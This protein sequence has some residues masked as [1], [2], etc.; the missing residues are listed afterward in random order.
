MSSPLKLILSLDGQ[1]VREVDLSKDRT[2]LGRRPYNDVVIDNLAVSGEHA[3]LQRI[4]DNVFLEDLNSTNGTYVNRKPVKRQML[5]PDDVIEIGRYRLQFARATEP[6]AAPA[7]PAFGTIADLSSAPQAR[8][9]VMG[10]TPDPTSEPTMVG[11]ALADLAQPPVAA[12]PVP[13]PQRDSE[14]LLVC[15]LH[16][17]SGKAE[18]KIM[19]L[20]KARTTLGKPGV[21]VAAIVRSADGVEV[22]IDD[23]RRALTSGEVLDIAGT[24]I[25]ILIP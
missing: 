23:T 25:E 22:Q 3:V 20:A 9:S 6:L 5:G 2:T 12:A 15:R 18:G 17:L 11:A 21:Q 24:R 10:D 14:G 13:A 4:G 19:P 7:L 16:V 8:E 1:V